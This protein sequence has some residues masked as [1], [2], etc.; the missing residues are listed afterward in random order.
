MNTLETVL[1]LAVIS[2]LAFLGFPV[3]I[4][5]KLESVSI[6]IALLIELSRTW[7]TPNTPHLI[8]CPSSNG[9]TCELT[10]KGVLVHAAEAPLYF[11][12][13]KG[14]SVTFSGPDG[15]EYLHLSQ[16]GAYPTPGHFTTSILGKSCVIFVN[17]QGRARADCS[18]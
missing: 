17:W 1:V 12:P 6:D 13:A 10:G 9:T 8:L 7:V 14:I 3:L 15:S 16:D 2:I 5:T 4:N 18:L 11:L